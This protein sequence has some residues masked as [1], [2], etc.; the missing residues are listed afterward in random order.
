VR[1]DHRIEHLRHRLRLVQ[2]GRNFR[3]L[4]NQAVWPAT[5]DWVFGQASDEDAAVVISCTR[6][7]VSVGVMVAGFAFSVAVEYDPEVWPLGLLL[8]LIAFACLAAAGVP[9][10]ARTV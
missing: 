7:V 1:L 2:T 5:S 9:R 6:I 4:A 8:A 3:V 10:T